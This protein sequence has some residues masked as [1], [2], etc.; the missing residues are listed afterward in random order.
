MLWEALFLLLPI[1]TASGWWFGWRAA[2]KR[3]V[4]SKAAI[5]QEYY[6]GLNYLINEQPDRATEIFL[7]MLDVDSES[8]EVHYALASLFLKRGEVLSDFHIQIALDLL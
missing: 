6:K 7:K 5:S 2:G 8:I 1:A 4:V 3:E